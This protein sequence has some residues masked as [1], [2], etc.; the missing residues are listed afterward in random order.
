MFRPDQLEKLRKDPVTGQEDP[1]LSGSG[2]SRADGKTTK[3]IEAT[4]P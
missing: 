4:C 1:I 3:T 2:P